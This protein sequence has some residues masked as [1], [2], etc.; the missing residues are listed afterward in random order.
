MAW[1]IAF[2]CSIIAALRGAYPNYSWWSLAYMFVVIIGVFVTVA[3][4][5]VY[6]YHVSVRCMTLMGQND[7]LIEDFRL[8]V[9]LVL[10]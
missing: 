10:D 8:L 5:A 3:A 1:I 6:T 9:S 4:D 2:V 7:V